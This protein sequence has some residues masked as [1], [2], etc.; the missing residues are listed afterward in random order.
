M[1]WENIEETKKTYYIIYPKLT[2]Y[3]VCNF[4]LLE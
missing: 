1:V 4:Y 2:I 3:F